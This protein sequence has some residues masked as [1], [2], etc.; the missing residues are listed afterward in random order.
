MLLDILMEPTEEHLNAAYSVISPT[1]TSWGV[2]IVVFTQAA[3]SFALSCSVS[4]FLKDLD[5]F[6]ACVFSHRCMG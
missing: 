4:S 6:N 2:A 5:W 1:L 3:A